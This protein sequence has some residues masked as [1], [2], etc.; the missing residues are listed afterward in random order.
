MTA[1]LPKSR[2]ITRE[3]LA[4]AVARETGITRPEVSA[5]LTALLNR[6]VV[7]VAAGKTVSLA[8]FGQFMPRK[9]HA[10][11]K[12]I[13]PGEEVKGVAFLPSP[14]PRPSATKDAR[15]RNFDL[16]EKIRKE[17]AR[18]SFA[19]TKLDK[20]RPLTAAEK[21]AIEEDRRA[22]LRAECVARAEADLEARRAAKARAE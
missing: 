8:S 22:I 9:R 6:I 7:E 15:V 13:A 12:P 17:R 20:A 10:G 1:A 18:A 3:A 5:V 21:R 11:D 19:R 14:C 4:N 2:N 16:R